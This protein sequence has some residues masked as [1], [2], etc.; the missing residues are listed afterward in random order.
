MR[1]ISS[2]VNDGRKGFGVKRGARSISAENTSAVTGEDTRLASDR[3]EL[4]R[5]VFISVW[6]LRVSVTLRD[7]GA[8]PATGW[9]GDGSRRR[10]QPQ[11]GDN[12][13]DGDSM[14][15]THTIAL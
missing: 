10:R 15:A 7:R 4:D 14:P 5:I 13:E 11:E 1:A 6:K 8:L 12:R 2:F 9:T 3:A